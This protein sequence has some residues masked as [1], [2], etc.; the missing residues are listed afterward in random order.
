MSAIKRRQ[1]VMTDATIIEAAADQA[2][3]ITPMLGTV[4]PMTTVCL[5]H[6]TLVAAARRRGAPDGKI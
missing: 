6:N 1:I 2:G 4:G 3:A 5:L